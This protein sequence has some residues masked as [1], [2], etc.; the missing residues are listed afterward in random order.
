LA[1]LVAIIGGDTLLGRELRDS[2]EQSG[3]AVRLRQVSTEEAEASV[4]TREDDELA[5]MQKLD[6][7][8]LEGVKIAFVTADAAA[9]RKAFALAADEAVTL[10][11][12]TGTLEELPSAQLRAPMAEARSADEMATHV[13]AH[14]AAIALA[15]LRRQLAGAGKLVR[16]VATICE[17]ASER[18]RAG[19]EELQ[20]QTVALLSFKAQP[21]AVYDAQVAFNLL[22]RVGDEAKVTLAAMEERIARHLQ[23]L[24]PEGPQPSLRLVQAPVFHG[25]VFSVWVEFE[26]PVAAD[27][28]EAE[29]V[30]DWIDL[31]TSE[32]EPPS[33]L[34]AAQQ[35][36]VQVTVQ[37]DR[38]N[39]RAAWLFAAADNVKLMADNAV[40]VAKAWLEPKRERVQ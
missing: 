31:R 18:G 24:A 7:S 9:A 40:Q 5:L 12:L 30:S 33:N 32:T 15:I 19:V 28:L 34:G 29:L 16:W 39:P 8:A 26:K 20:Q 6:E 14:P 22:P 4:V 38:A 3:L 17:P 21:Q 2:L 1:E 10:V 36:G 35:A 27:D 13:V 37:F 23:A 25:H 11:D